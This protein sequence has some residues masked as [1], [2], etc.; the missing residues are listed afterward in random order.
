M[1]WTYPALMLAAV[2]LGVVLSRRTQRSLR[3]DPSQ[4]A[5][6]ALGAFWGAMLGAK[7]PFVLTDWSGLVSGRA[8]IGSGK[9]IVFGLVGG[10]AGVELAKRLL[11][12]RVKTAD[13]FAVPVA[14]S[15]AVGRLA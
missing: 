6:L 15:V 8:W 14:A 13:T 4:R 10:Y 1:H 2:V 9:T 3:L 12:I 11:D 5:G 7:L